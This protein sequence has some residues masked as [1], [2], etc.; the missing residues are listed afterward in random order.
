FG[1]P[2][3]SPNN[4]LGDGCDAN[5]VAFKGSFPY[6]ANAHQGYKH[7]PHEPSCSAMPPSDTLGTFTRSF[8]LLGGR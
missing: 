7:G 3:L 4:T 8:P 6:L 2:N 1:L 5:D